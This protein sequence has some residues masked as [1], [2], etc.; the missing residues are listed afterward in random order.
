MGQRCSNC[1]WRCKAS[2]PHNLA[3][4]WK[5]AGVVAG[6]RPPAALAAVGNSEMLTE[7]RTENSG[8]SADTAPRTK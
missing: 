2:T 1:A 5:L 7:R 4:R 3:K 8:N 6:C